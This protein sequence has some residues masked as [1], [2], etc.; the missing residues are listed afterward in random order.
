MKKIITLLCLFSCIFYACKTDTEEAKEDSIAVSEAANTENTE[1]EEP[2]IDIGDLMNVMGG[3]LNPGVSQDTT[4]QGLFTSSGE[5]NIAYLKSEEGKPLRKTFAQIA[6]VSEDEVDL[7]LNLMPDDN[8]V[9]VKHA[10][11]IE[12]DLN[13]AEV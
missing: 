11:E 9:S 6:G 2:E 7:S 8:I 13:N 10:E 1:P 4:S 3:L 5:L 12:K